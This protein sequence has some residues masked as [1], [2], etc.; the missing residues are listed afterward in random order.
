MLFLLMYCLKT[1]H[2]LRIV[3]AILFMIVVK[4]WFLVFS[5]TLCCEVDL[6]ELNAGGQDLFA[7]GG[8]LDPVRRGEGG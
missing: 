6:G 4:M 7:G 3:Y 2:C 5:E 8:G 1:M